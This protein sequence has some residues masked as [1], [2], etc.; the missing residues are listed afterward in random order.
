MLRRQ[1]PS[2]QQDRSVYDHQTWQDGKLL[3][4][5]PTHKVT[6]PF[7]HVVL[8]DHMTNQNYYISTK[9]NKEFPIMLLDPLIMWFGEVI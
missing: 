8:K 5:A 2:T 7:D 1:I 9:Y 4:L 3:W 6:Q